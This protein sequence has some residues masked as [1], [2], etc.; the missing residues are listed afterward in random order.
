MSNVYRKHPVA[1]AVSMALLAAAA[2]SATA[3]G[4]TGAPAENAGAPD[5]AQQ[6]A[7]TVPAPDIKKA[8]SGTTDT[9]DKTLETVTV[10]GVRQSQI[11][12][13]EAKRAAPSIQDS[14]SAEAIGQLPDVT[15]TDALQRITGVQINRDA[16]VGTSVAVRG[17]PQVGTMLNGEVFISPDQIDAQQPDFTTLPATM[18]NQVDVIKSPT[19]SQTIG[20]ISGA[21][22]L[23]TFRPWDLPHGFT[24]SYSADGERGSTSR[25]TGPEASGLISYNADGRWGLQVSG[26]FSDTTRFGTAGG[27]N[28]GGNATESLD[29]YGVLLHGE[30]AVSAGAYNGFLGA[31][32]GA[33]IPSQIHQFPDGS[34]DVNGDGKNN[35]VFMGSQ[36]IG[37][38]DSVVERK[39]HAINASFQADLSNGF[40][41]TS[42]YFFA[43]QTQ[44]DRSVGI[45]FNSTNWQGATYVPLQSRDTGSTVI[46]SYNT[47]G[48]AYAASWAGSHLYT[49]QIYE[50]YPGDVESYSQVIRRESAAQN[51]NLQVDFDNGGPFKASVRGVRETAKQEYI[52]TDINIS[53]SDGCLW[54]DP[55]TSLP[56]GTFVY[57]AALG[58]NRVF[59]ANGIPQNTV[60]IVAN[61][62]GRNIGITLPASLAADFANPN[63]WTMKTL[64]SNDDYDRQ[65]AIT[66][67]R[68]DG[69]YKFNDSFNF[70]FGVRNSIRSARN[71]GFTLV[72]PVYAGIGASDPNGCLV[73]YVG[74]DVILSGNATDTTPSTWCTAGNADGAFR[75]GPLSSQQLSKTPA[76]LASNFQ[77]YNNLLG[78]GITFWAINPNALD[79]PMGYW[80]S[81]YPNT[82]TQAAPGI[83]WAVSM[84]ETSTYL[85]SDFN[86]H[87]AGMSFS[88]NLGA[89]L[90]H[91]DLS[92]TQHLTGAPGQYGTEPADAGTEVTHRS[93]NDVLPALNLA[94]NVTDQFTTRF[95]VSKNMMPLDLSTWGGGL[96]LN[97]SLQE[98]KTGPIYQV[99]TG[100]AFGN[101]SLNPWRSTNYGLSFE[102]YINP[103]SMVNLELF[104]IDVKS[105]I[106]NGSVTNC[107]LPDEDGVVRHHCIAINQ[108]LQGSGNSIQG[109][110]FDYRQG[111]TFLPGLLRNTGMEFNFTYAPSKTGE[112]DLAGKQIP[113]QDNSTESGNFILWYDD[114]HFEVRLAY[115]YRSKRAFMENVGGISGLEEYEAPQRYLDASAAFKFSKYAQLFVDATNLT[116]EYQRFYLVWPDQFGHANF[117][118][119]MFTVGLRGQW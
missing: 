77:Q 30:N 78:S 52:E 35:G 17:L 10:V 87:L 42:D 61:F 9:D 107:D 83:T 82:T 48:D 95:S 2:A 29:Q 104:H 55:S 84:R 100:N 37:L 24:Y 105:F 41:L 106:F 109:A 16:G 108:P 11:K 98:T 32:N 111:F 7:T 96:Q 90:I 44:Y 33:P 45:Q 8:R 5:P 97:Y 80:K 18:F 43:H 103:T 27:V 81:L 91:T 88:G 22:D 6:D 118:E 46:G 68:F 110:E 89:R 112:T 54:A 65:T 93:Y 38:Y 74:S 72:T 49:T 14:I 60:P 28:A 92:I 39:R 47:P 26:D 85:Q 36:D 1:I 57:P 58:G 79:D 23:H 20:G 119:R 51:I 59:N 15:I 53:D 50:K 71:D 34:V 75:A 116:N 4:N 3:S 94:L 69:H 102:Y 13:I 86:G 63:A 114:K 70:N 12:S 67:L 115:N 76:P 40:T 113:F 101:P 19:A 66:A 117:S 56:C 99:A 73:R 31:W 25:K 64:E 62:T 21:L